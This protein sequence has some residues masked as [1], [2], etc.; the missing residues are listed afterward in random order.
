MARLFRACC[1]HDGR[2]HINPIFGL[3]IGLAFYALLPCTVVYYFSS[4]IDALTAYG[5]EL[6]PD[7]SFW[8]ACLTLALLLALNFGVSVY[9]ASGTARL[10][11]FRRSENDVYRRWTYSASWPAAAVMWISFLGFVGLALS[12]RDSLFSGYQTDVLADDSVWAARGAMSS[13]YSAFYL[14]SCTYILLR[15]NHLTKLAVAFLGL[16]FAVCSMILLSMGARLYV[17]MALI[18]L[19]A[20]KS[21]LSNGLPA[22]QLLT[23][24]LGGAL[25]M[26]AVGVLRSDSLESLADIFKNLLLEPLLTSIS[27]FTLLSDN[28]PIFFGKPH[29]LFADFQ[30]VMP[31]ILFPNKSGLFDRLADYGYAFEAPVGGHHLYFS[32]I[33]NFGIIGTI[34]LAPLVGYILARISRQPLSSRI[35]T[36]TLLCAIYMTGA[37]AFTIFRDPFFISLAKNVLVMA[38]ILPLLLTRWRRVHGASRAP[39][40]QER[41]LAVS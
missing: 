23:F 32:C 29:L 7:N 3:L 19:L 25:C 2:V 16:T 22:R 34:L 9:K 10:L 17:A 8:L 26:G 37:M 12:V 39:A 6:N 13:F 27:I 36:S 40:S 35:R 31:S 4:I 21:V 11:R 1:I 41:P 30:A 28:S 14:S 20:L 24:L 5:R 18:S 15:R 33:I 38:I